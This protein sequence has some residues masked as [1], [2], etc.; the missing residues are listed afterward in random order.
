VLVVR[1]DP[2]LGHDVAQVL[3]LGKEHAPEI[4]Q[5]FAPHAPPIGLHVAV[6]QRVPVPLVP[7]MPFVH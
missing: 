1:I 5:S 3:P 6:Q 4:V 2:G 7:Q